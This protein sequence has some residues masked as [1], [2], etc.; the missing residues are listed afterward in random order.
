MAN[1]A[2]QP[3]SQPLGPLCL[4]PILHERVWGSSTLPFGHQPPAPGKPVGEAWLTALECIAEGEHAHGQTLAEIVANRP[5]LFP[6]AADFPLLIKLL[7]PREKLSVQV[8]PND[9]EA[10]AGGQPR[11]KTEC[12]YVL[13]AEPGAEVAVGLRR[14]LSAEQLRAA[15]ENGT[16]EQELQYIPVKAGDMVY[17]DAGTIHAI[18]PG[19]VVL[20]TQQYSDITYR[21]YDYGRGRDLHIEQGVAVA[22]ASTR[23]GLVAPVEMEG[24]TRLIETPYFVIDRFSVDTSP[25]ALGNSC[26]MQIVVALDDVCFLESSSGTAVPLL[27]GRA[28]VLPA[29]AIAYTLRAA[30]SSTIIRI[31]ER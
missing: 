21:L 16:L 26:A 3:D 31:A 7:F 30:F 19:I 4:R 24:F 29:E 25:A 9:A 17:V 15:I 23:A 12:W 18:G 14:E 8:H 27:P 22:K 5:E 13:S 11:G 10:Q 28:A 2:A 6:N 20:E 1:L